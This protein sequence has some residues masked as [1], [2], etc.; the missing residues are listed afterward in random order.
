MDHRP[1]MR[2]LVGAGALEPL[3]R[4]PQRVPQLSDAELERELTKAA[5]ARTLDR[6]RLLDVLFDELDRRRGD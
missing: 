3:A 1:E 4:R 2:L 5:S 6:G